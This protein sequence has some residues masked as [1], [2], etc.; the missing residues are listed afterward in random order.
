MYVNGGP[1]P[2]RLGRVFTLM[3]YTALPY[4][5]IRWRDHPSMGNSHDVPR[6]YQELFWF[7]GWTLLRESHGILS[8]VFHL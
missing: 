7:D 4:Q 5:E 1:L 8:P 2:V 3:P 6:C